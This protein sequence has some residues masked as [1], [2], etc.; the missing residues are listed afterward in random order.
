[1]NNQISLFKDKKIT[2]QI[3]NNL[4]EIKESYELPD[5]LMTLL[6]DNNSM[7]M[8]FDKF[9][10][11]DIDLTKDLFRDYFQEQHADRKGLKQDYTPDAICKIISKLQ[12]EKDTILDVC[13]GT[14]ALSLFSYNENNELSITCEEISQRSISTL[15]FNLAIRNIHGYV[16]RKDVLK[17]EILDVYQLEKGEKYSIIT[18]VE[19]VK[20]RKYSTIISNPPYSI[21]WQPK[22]DERFNNYELAPKS[23]ADFAFILDILYRLDENGKAFMILPHGVLF[24]EQAEGK[25]RKQLID[26]NLIDS[27]IGLPDK[28]FLNTQIPTCILIL[29]KNK[30][31]NNILFIDSSKNCINQAKQNDMSDEQI[32]KI[33]ETYKNRK[34]IEK[35][36]H[37]ATYDEIVKN[38]YNLNIPRYVDTFEDEPLPDLKETVQ[39]L[40]KLEKETKETEHELKKMLERLE[41]TTPE[42]KEYYSKAIKPLMEWLV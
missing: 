15:L 24:R 22:Y 33:I 1:M 40:I 20:Q 34:E 23:K 29:N 16:Y 8:L 13:S 28:M 3:I 9:M 5:K 27:I 21:E 31:D 35:Y 4:L 38:D 12:N 42:E 26:N 36:S 6:L 19:N 39:D 10:E 32:N 18:K 17:N 14:G 30:K 2:N 25:I 37:L 7:T 41:G 11:Y